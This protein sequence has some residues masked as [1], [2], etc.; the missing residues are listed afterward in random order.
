MTMPKRVY[1]V[2]GS[3]E[4]VQ[5]AEKDGRLE[6]RAYR[7][8]SDA[9]GWSWEIEAAGDGE[10]LSVRWRREGARAAEARFRWEADAWVAAFE[11]DGRAEET[12]WPMVK[13]LQAVFPAAV[14]DYLLLRRAGL[15]PGAQRRLEA[16]AVAAGTLEGGPTHLLIDRLDEASYRVTDESGRA[17]GV[18]VDADG[19]PLERE[20]AYRFVE[21]S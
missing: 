18:R 12:V 4:S 14:S 6:M 13:G 21:A 8:V 7:K 15:R 5:W 20:G 11:G 3:R 19:W 17:A 10:V 9:E 16:L 1:D 2:D